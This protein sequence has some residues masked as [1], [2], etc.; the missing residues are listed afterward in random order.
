MGLWFSGM[1]QDGVRQCDGLQ[2]M[3]EVPMDPGEGHEAVGG[4][5]TRGVRTRPMEALAGG[6]KRHL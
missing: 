2:G 6:G 4:L 1:E 3:K 5:R